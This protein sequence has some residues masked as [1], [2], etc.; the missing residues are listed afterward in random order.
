MC[1]IVIRSVIKHITVYDDLVALPFEFLN[2][3]A[4]KGSSTAH[5]FST[6]V[7]SGSSSAPNLKDED[8]PQHP[9]GIG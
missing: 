3:L 1:R 2:E 4:A 9:D 6:A 5:L 8:M 7:I